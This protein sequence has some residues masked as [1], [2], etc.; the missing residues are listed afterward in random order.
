MANIAI[1]WKLFKKFEE[2]K[3]FIVWRVS[4]YSIVRRWYVGEGRAQR[5]EVADG[6]RG[7]SC[8][9]CL[10]SLFARSRSPFLLTGFAVPGTVYSPP[11]KYTLKKIYD[12]KLPA[13]DF[14]GE[15]NPL[16]LWVFD[17]VASLILHHL[18]KST[19][20]SI[21]LQYMLAPLKMPHLL[22]LAASL[23]P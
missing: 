21:L 6:F 11:K 23:R 2:K 22:L 15:E 5:T 12:I 18:E 17:M 20:I 3:Y 19:L 7:C 10:A 13:D 14:V 16:H 4:L 8:Q 9:A 1:K